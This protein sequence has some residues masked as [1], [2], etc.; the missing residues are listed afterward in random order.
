MNGYKDKWKQIDIESEKEWAKKEEEKMQKLEE[1][2]KRI[3]SQLSEEERISPNK[4]LS[5]AEVNSNSKIL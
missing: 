1:I 5:S 2:R 4:K 3:E